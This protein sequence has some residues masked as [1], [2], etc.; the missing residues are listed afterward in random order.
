VFP[1]L[2]GIK[3][4]IL[5]NPYR[6]N[7]STHYLEFLFSILLIKLIIISILWQDIMSNIVN[8]S[9]EFRV[10]LERCSFYVVT[11]WNDG[12][13]FHVLN[14]HPRKNE[15]NKR[16]FWKCMVQLLFILVFKSSFKIRQC[17]VKVAIMLTNVLLL[18]YLIM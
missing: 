10:R 13:T 11:S 14:G 1:Y 17:I 18:F 2:T 6:L 9:N 7:L 8:V 5:N 4:L 16:S 3:R 12:V 15:K